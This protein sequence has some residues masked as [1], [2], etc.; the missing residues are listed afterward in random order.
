MPIFTYAQCDDVTSVPLA[1]HL[2]PFY[3]VYNYII[4]RRRIIVDLTSRLL[5]II[6]INHDG[7]DENPDLSNMRE[8]AGPSVCAPQL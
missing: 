6:G 2:V 4:A 8:R 3:V 7:R 5:V 1:E